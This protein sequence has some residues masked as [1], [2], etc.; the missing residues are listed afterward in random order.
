M[1]K[2]EVDL[3]VEPVEEAL[4]LLLGAVGTSERP[5]SQVKSINVILK[6]ERRPERIL[7]IPVS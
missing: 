4:G 2:V 3:D 1:V 6:G 5:P 7:R